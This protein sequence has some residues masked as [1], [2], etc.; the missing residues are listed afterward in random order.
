MFKYGFEHPS[1]ALNSS[2]VA[3]TLL[4]P[5]TLRGTVVLNIKPKG[6]DPITFY[7]DPRTPADTFALMRDSFRSYVRNPYPTNGVRQ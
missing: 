2:L 1:G 3:S 7:A 5:G 6:V 4:M